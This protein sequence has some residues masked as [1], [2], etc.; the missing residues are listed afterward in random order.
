MGAYGRIPFGLFLKRKLQHLESDLHDP[1]PRSAKRQGYRAVLC[2]ILM[3]KPYAL[4]QRPHSKASYRTLVCHYAPHR[5][6][7]AC[8]I[9]PITVRSCC[10]DQHRSSSGYGERDIRRQG[11]RAAPAQQRPDRSRLVRLYFGARVPLRSGVFHGC[12]VENGLISASC[13]AMRLRRAH[14]QSIGSRLCPF[15][16]IQTEAR[17]GFWVQLLQ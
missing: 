15:G 2:Q 13:S 4:C 1:A 11:Y 17:S 7:H 14:H 10:C 9:A 8:A 5:S 6:L 3:S 16:P 12:R